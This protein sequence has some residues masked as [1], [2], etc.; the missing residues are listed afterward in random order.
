VCTAYHSSE[1][2]W[3]ILNLFSHRPKCFIIMGRKLELIFEF[4]FFFW[5]LHF[6]SL[7]F[8]QA[9]NETRRLHVCTTSA[10]FA[11]NR[12][13]HDTQQS[14]TQHISI[15]D[16]LNRTLSYSYTQCCYAGSRYAEDM[17]K[18]MILTRKP[19]FYSVRYAECIVAARSSS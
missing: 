15:S 5:V 2:E 19:L 4:L 9:R 16:K 11:Q 1:A 6:F 10:F 17:S 7:S 8:I 12:W 13:R 14:D 3:A 18:K